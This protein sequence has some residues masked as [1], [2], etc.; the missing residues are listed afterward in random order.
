MKF[1]LFVALILATEIVALA[2]LGTL[3]P[4]APVLALVPV[5]PLTLAVALLV[6]WG[7]LNSA[8]YRMSQLSPEAIVG[9]RYQRPA[10]DT[11]E[12]LSR[13]IVER[14]T[15]I[16]R[17]LAESPSEIRVEMC[18]LGY[19]ACVNDMITLTH[20]AN[21]E[22]PNAGILRRMK[23]RRARKKATDALA[24]AREALPPGALRATRQEQQ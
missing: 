5:V 2:V 16:R 20:L 18:T 12:D 15:E 3:E 23:L 11:P 21:E 4:G 24:E 8:S 10:T 17:T 14:A 6:R 13:S 9:H 19:R 1:R 22:L 7:L